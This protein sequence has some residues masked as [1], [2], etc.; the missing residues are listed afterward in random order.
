[1]CES[2]NFF[3]SSPTLAV[4]CFFD[5]SHPTVCEVVSHF[6]AIFQNKI[7]PAVM[8]RKDCMRAR[9]EAIV[10]GRIYVLFNK[11]YSG[12]ME[13][14]FAL[15]VKKIDQLFLSPP[16]SRGRYFPLAK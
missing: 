16:L 10:I 12:R 15:S 1:M 2:Y 4:V 3:A 5:Y 14:E 11:N 9:A 6:V 8:L 13:N 7:T